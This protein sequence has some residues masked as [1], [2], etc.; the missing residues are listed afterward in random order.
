MYPDGL[1]KQGQAD[2][3]SVKLHQTKA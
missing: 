3:L 1:P 2:G